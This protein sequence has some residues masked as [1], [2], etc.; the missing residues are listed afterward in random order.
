VLTPPALAASVEVQPASFGPALS[1]G[2][3]TTGKVVV[4]DDGVGAA[5][6]A[7]EPLVG[8]VGANNANG[9]IVLADRGVCTFV[10]KVAN[11]QAAGAKG[12]IIA[13]N[14]A[15]GLPGMGGVDPTITI[16]SVGVT[17]A[18]GDALRTA[19]AGNSVVKLLL[20]ANELAGAVD[21]FVRLFA[22]NPVQ[23]GSSGSHWDVTPSPN[24]LMEPFINSDL[25]AADTL[26]LTP[27]LMQDIG[28]TLLP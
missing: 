6:D 26:D 11:A 10:A 23:G 5:G 7:C 22:P 24:L 13:N 1:G 12:V 15:V 14:V 25:R 28:W 19:A 8:N 18:F 17:Q 16:P 2:G 9:K 21:G 3:G 4:A 20:D 27:A